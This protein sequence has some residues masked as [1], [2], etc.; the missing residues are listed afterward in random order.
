MARSRPVAIV[1]H[2]E[3]RKG[4]EGFLSRLRKRKEPAPTMAKVEHSHSTNP[5]TGTHTET[6]KKK[7]HPRGLESGGHGGRGPMAKERP[8]VSKVQRRKPGIGDKLSGAMKKMEG[9]VEG[10]PGKKVRCRSSWMFQ[11]TGANDTM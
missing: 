10:K 5:I 2:R 11:N 8:P 3:P 6:T 4:N 9:T 7:T 1:E